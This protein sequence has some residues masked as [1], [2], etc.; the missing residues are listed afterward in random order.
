MKPD[1]Y[2]RLCNCLLSLDM[3][4]TWSIAGSKSGSRG[5]TMSLAALMV[6]MGWAWSQAVEAH[7]M[8]TVNNT[9]S[10]M[11]RWRSAPLR[12][13]MKPSLVM[14]KSWGMTHTQ[15]PLERLQGILSIDHRLSHTSQCKIWLELVW[16]QSDPSEFPSWSWAL[17]CDCNKALISLDQQT[18][19]S[20]VD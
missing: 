2:Y 17:H 8:K 13:W 9:H 19:F 4:I 20:T 10:R 12:N 1:S 15:I 18:F 6:H 7:H 11:T 16:H 14:P 3:G 5:M